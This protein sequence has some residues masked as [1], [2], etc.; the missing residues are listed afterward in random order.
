MAWLFEFIF[1]SARFLLKEGFPLWSVFAMLLFGVLMFIILKN[2][3]RKFSNNGNG[4]N[5]RMSK[6]D[7]AEKREQIKD[8]IN[9]AN[10]AQDK[11]AFERAEKI[12]KEIHDQGKDLSDKL[13]KVLI[14]STESE[15]T[16][17]I[18]TKI[19]TDKFT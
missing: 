3:V 19:V 8:Y 12:Y 10:N 11:R 1:K 13:E 17:N 2:L 16:L 9:T 5:G 15:K 14:K 6:I 18:L 4:V 7:C